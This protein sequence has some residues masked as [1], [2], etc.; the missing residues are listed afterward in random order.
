MAGS[1]LNQKAIGNQKGTDVNSVCSV[2]LLD[3][4]SAVLLAAALFRDCCPKQI[5]D[6]TANVSTL[7]IVEVS[8]VQGVLSDHAAQHTAQKVARKINQS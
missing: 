3:K 7:S 5:T 8:R 4:C 2:Y 6:S 1:L